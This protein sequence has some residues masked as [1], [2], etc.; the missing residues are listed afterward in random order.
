MKNSY[1]ALLSGLIL[2]AL[3]A[4]SWCGRKPASELTGLSTPSPTATPTPSPSPVASATPT[5]TPTPSPANVEPSPT[6]AP[7][8]T[9][10]AEL[11]KA[12][13]KVG[14]AVIL[15]TTFDASGKLLRTGT[16]FFATSDG[17]LITTWHLVQNAAYAVAKSPD[18]KI[19][20]VTG[21]VASSGPLDLAVL[22]AET[23]TGVPF[24]RMTKTAEAKSAVALLGSTLA[25]REQPLAALQITGR[26][27]GAGGD[28]LTPS[29]PVS[30]DASGAPIIDENGEVAG[31]VALTNEP[32]KP[33][34]VVLRPAD[35]LTSLLAQTRADSEGRWT[36]APNESPTPA[37]KGKV[38]FNPSPTYP[39][40]GRSFNPPLAGSG[41][42]RI[43]FDAS[44]Q[45]KEVQIV[46][47][48]GQPILDRA[49]V[50][51]FGKWK[52]TPGHEW[53]L[54]IPITFQP[55]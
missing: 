7:I 29:V 52:S 41:R 51:A 37:P 28:L 8:Q 40:R 30:A 47:S 31:I 46:R 35:A 5:A 54:V 11:K 13:A 16:G 45:A 22:K 14:P 9:P 3:I 48:T 21:V 24:A 6:P 55:R 4:M 20:N 44:G 17:R 27:T 49:A 15:V 34:T 18:G 1:L 53:T 26:E 2:F 36:G 50:E 25:R 33:P 42:F 12:S 38:V 43:V 39:D 19:R 32:N 10:S 23:K